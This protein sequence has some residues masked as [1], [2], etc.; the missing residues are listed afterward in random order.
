[1]ARL[2]G[3]VAR[4]ILVVLLIAAPSL[5]TA[6][7]SPDSAQVVALVAIAAALLTA[8]EYASSSPCLY[9]FRDAPPFNRIRFASLFA[10][11]FLMAVLV[12]GQTVPTSMS[13]FV[14]GIG[15]FMGKAI[16]FRYSPVRLVVLL[17]PEDADIR[18]L[19]LL[20]AAAG[21]AYVIS[22]ISLIVFFVVM[23]VKNWP[24]NSGDFNVWINL[25]TF[26]PTS[27]GDVVDRLE[28]DSRVNVALGFLLPFLMPVLI[29]SASSLFG[30]VTLENP[31]TMIWMVA[32]WAFLPAS[33]FM[34]GMA[35]GRLAAIIA[36]K[37]RN[38]SQDEGG[39]VP[40]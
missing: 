7:T 2:A 24:L 33:L 15:G 37:R 14:E 18:Q 21:L 40:A 34:R 19:L 5:L 32:A 25:P 26:D 12:R 28:R 22:L 30:A 1:M 38:A 17:L 8:V 3:A 36:A 4:G 13:L 27:G 31:Q 16:D 6:T 20:R 11:V 9:E 35:L 10:M 29:E 39:F 23:R